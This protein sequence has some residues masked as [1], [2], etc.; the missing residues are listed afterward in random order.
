MFWWGNY[1]SAT[2]HIQ[3]KHLNSFRS[4]LVK[5]FRMLLDNNIFICVNETPWEYHFEN[6]NFALLSNEHFKLIET[7]HFIKLSKKIP[8]ESYS[9]ITQFSSEYF[10]LL[11]KVLTT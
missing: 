2:I 9:S 5:N 3:G 7:K 8:L 6:D 11:L 4:K 10:T 1:F